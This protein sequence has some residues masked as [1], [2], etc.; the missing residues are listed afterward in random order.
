M[1]L[2]LFMPWA[3]AHPGLASW[4]QAVFS[5]LAII[6]AFLIGQQQARAALKSTER[7]HQLLQAEK[8]RSI[9]AIIQ[10][11]RDIVIGIGNVLKAQTEIAMTR[12][13]LYEVYDE[14]VIDGI[15]GA[16]ASIPIYDVGSSDGVG[17]L[18]KL[19]YHIVF[20]GNNVRAFIDG[21]WNHPEL[22][23]GLEQYPDDHVTRREMLEGGN[24]ILKKNALQQ[25]ELVLKDIDGLLQAIEAA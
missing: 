2:Q 22:R 19:R 16:L 20:F 6:A 9:E 25:F 23:L 14:V 5:I 7:A 15:S 13:A 21:P 8:R 10:S 4:V 1:P 18:Q 17:A 11:T 12:A 3:D 24:E